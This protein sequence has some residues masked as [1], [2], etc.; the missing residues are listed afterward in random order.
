MAG[1]IDHVGL[2]RWRL[3]MGTSALNVVAS[4]GVDAG[5]LEMAGTDRGTCLALPRQV[6]V[7]NGESSAIVR[8]AISAD[9]LGNLV[10]RTT[11]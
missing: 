1:N 8:H 6:L 11:A 10:G 9:L 5:Q 7:T 4:L 2:S 3:Q